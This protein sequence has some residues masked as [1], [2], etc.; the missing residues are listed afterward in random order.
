LNSKTTGLEPTSQLPTEDLFQKGTFTISVIDHDYDPPR[1]TPMTIAIDP[2]VDTLESVGKRINGIPHITAGWSSDGHLQIAA[3]D[4]GR[5]TIALADI[6]SNFLQATGVSS[7]FMQNQGITQSIADLDTLM[8][9]LTRQVSNFGARANR[10]GV[11]SQ[12]YS[13]MTIAT[14]ENLSEAQ[15]TDM[16]KA[17]MELKA[18]ETAYQAALSAA[19]K[20]MQ[21][22]LVDYLR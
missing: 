2:A 21:L 7:E 8:E 13:A 16:I 10:I 3:S 22:S 4:P 19:A 11:Q 5:Y 9:N 14:K 1:T 15:D 20:T 12:I 6:N 18:K 17:V